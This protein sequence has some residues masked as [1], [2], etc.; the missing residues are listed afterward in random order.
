V[1]GI[2]GT[3]RRTL[4]LDARTSP[5]PS[6]SPDGFRIVFDSWSNDYYHDPG[7]QVVDLNGDEYLLTYPGQAAEWSPDGTRVA[8]SL[9]NLRDGNQLGTV[10]AI[11]AGRRVLTKPSRRFSANSP[12]WSTDGSTLTY[13]ESLA[14]LKPTDGEFRQVGADGRGSHPVADD[15]R[16]GTGASDRIHGSRHAD[17]I[18][19]L[20]G[21][22]RIDVRGGGRDFVDCGPGRDVVHADRRDVIARDC[23]RRFR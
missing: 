8:Y 22:D 3:G 1:I 9:T 16:F 17:T 19:A 6:W 2:D 5:E 21:N 18:Y 13:V 14:G 10:S 11:G 12:T 7:L 20:E 23:E 15:C 4:A